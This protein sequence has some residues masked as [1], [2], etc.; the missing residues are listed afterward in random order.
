[1]CTFIKIEKSN[2]INDENIENIETIEIT[3][4]ME[5]TKIIELLR[6]PITH[7]I[8]YDPVIACDMNTYEREAIEEWFRINN[9]SPTTHEQ[10]STILIENRKVKQIVKQLLIEHPEYETECY[11]TSSINITSI[12]RKSESTE[13]SGKEKDMVYNSETIRKSSLND[14]IEI[15]KQLEENKILSDMIIY[16]KW[17]TDIFEII[18]RNVCTQKQFIQKTPTILVK[19]TLLHVLIEHRQTMMSEID[20]KISHLLSCKNINIDCINSLGYTALQIAIYSKEFDIAEKLINKGAKFT[21]SSKCYKNSSKSLHNISIEYEYDNIIQFFIETCF[22]TNYMPS[23][24]IIKAMKF[25]YFMLDK[26]TE[27]TEHNIATWICYFL[28]YVSSLKIEEFNKKKQIFYKDI[29]GDIEQHLTKNDIYYLTIYNIIKKL[30]DRLSDV[31]IKLQTI[32]KI[33]YQSHLIHHVLVHNNE[34][35]LDILLE[36]NFDT[37]HYNYFM[38]L[39]HCAISWCDNSLLLKIISKYTNISN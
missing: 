28:S 35:V 14:F 13:D 33:Q 22:R 39:S 18:P 2:I 16:E 21:F 19:N 15:I 17:K 3:N 30:I 36:R 27:Y 31:N 34:H 26:Y 1:M 4:K 20:N 23:L 6:C 29:N 12:I 5:K 24:R 10:I 7:K 11:K 38:P 32:G 37:T 8:F 9:T 25:L